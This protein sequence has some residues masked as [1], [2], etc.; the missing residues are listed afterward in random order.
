MDGGN[1]DARQDGGSSPC[2]RGAIV[3]LTDY[4]STQIALTATDGTPLS[5]AFLSTASTKASGVAFPLSGDVV[6]PAV[7]PR[8]ARVVLLDRFGTNVVTW[9]DPTTAKVLAQLP[10]GT[11]FESNPQDYVELDDGRAY[12]TRWGK[13]A[14]PGAHPFDVGSDVLVVD[15]RTPT[16]TASIPM[17]SEDGLPPRPSGMLRIGDTVVVVLQRVSED[18]KTVGENALVGVS[19]DAVAWQA[20]V[21]GLK[22]CGRPALSPSG[23]IMA[24]AC[25]G[26]LATDG[27][28]VDSTASAIALYDV[29]S[30]PPRETQ[31]FAVADQLGASTQDR[32][33][34]ASETLLLGKTQTALG[35]TRDNQAFALD[36]A[37]GKAAV[38]LTAGKDP[39]GQ[40]KGIVYGDVRCTPGCGDVCLMTDADLGKL[41]RWKIAE[42]GL[43]GLDAIKVET[44]VG[45]PPVGLGGY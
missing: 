23:K 24:L 40:G 17:P 1:D 11:G 38:L 9:A 8:S 14:A 31:R 27:S 3:V 25:E 30:L 12:I 22:G 19:N 4:T 6:V 44:A 35:G 41:Q 18:F 39:N 43:H 5:A 42:D 26:Q 20:H 21:T 45:L 34:F 16:I 28:V 15:T 29:T 13:N 10:V 36:V 37:S 33:A 32:V 7:A 2:D